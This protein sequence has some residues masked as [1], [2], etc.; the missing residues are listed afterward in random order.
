MNESKGIASN[1]VPNG[2]IPRNPLPPTVLDQLRRDL[3]ALK[4]NAMAQCLDEALILAQKTEPGYIAF[5][6][7]L[8]SQ[9]VLW[10]SERAVTRRLAQA[11]FPVVKTFDGLIGRRAAS[12]FR[13]G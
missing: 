4:L 7:G 11:S 5:F 10:A 1:D 2:G 8:V 3:E 13:A 6:A 9:Q 12:A